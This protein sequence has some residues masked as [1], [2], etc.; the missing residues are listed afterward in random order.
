MAEKK[1]GCILNIGERKD[2]KDYNAFL[3]AVYQKIKEQVISFYD[4]SGIKYK[5]SEP[6]RMLEDFFAYLYRLIPPQ[7]REVFYSKQIKQKINDKVIS[8]EE[9]KVLFSFEESFRTG[10]D[11]NEYLSVKTKDSRNPDFLL[12]TWHLYHLHLSSKTD[13][14]K[15]RS[16]TQLLC[17]VTGESVY[18]VD[19]IVHP[20]IG[21]DYFDIHHLRTIVENGWIEKI[22]FQV[23]PGMIPGTMN[24]VVTDS[25]T[26]FDLYT[27]GLNTGFEFDGVGY[28]SLDPIMA[29]KRPFASSE[30]INRIN[31]NIRKLLRIK[32]DFVDVIMSGIGNKLAILAAFKSGDSRVL[33]CYDLLSK[34]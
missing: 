26:L 2:A 10:K 18:F 3:D 16:N 24:P 30:T 29:N 5:D 21:C 1:C 23:I 33:E 17:I 25:K 6:G 34:V 4:K 8:E 13:M 15:N 22:G 9:S 31:K 14:S 11:M 7:K 20:K 28:A 12:Y 32:D 27:H 19:V